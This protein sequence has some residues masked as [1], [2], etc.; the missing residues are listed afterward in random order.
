MND[1]RHDT[2]LQLRARAQDTLVRTQM[3]DDRDDRDTTAG[4]VVAGALDRDA[5]AAGGPHRQQR[6]ARAVRR[7]PAA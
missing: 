5:R 3:D 1:G 6:H 2:D 4:T 7:E